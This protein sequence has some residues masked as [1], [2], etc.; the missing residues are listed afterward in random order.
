MVRSLMKLNF[1]NLALVSASTCFALFITWLFA[2]HLLLGMWGIEHTYAVGLVSRRAAALFLA[3]AVMFFLARNAAP[4]PSRS[5][6]VA[7]FVTGCFSL[8]ALGIFEWL[9]GKASIG[10]FIAV[11]VEIALALAFLIASDSVSKSPDFST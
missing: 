7:G 11:T 10:I 3:I 6:L 9:S 4:S 1:K 2:P 5:A 8:A